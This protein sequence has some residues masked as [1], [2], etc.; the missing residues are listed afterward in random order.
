MEFRSG[1]AEDGRVQVT[2]SF[3]HYF[4]CRYILLRISQQVLCPTMSIQQYPKEDLLVEHQQ[5]P[6]KQEPF[7]FE[8]QQECALSVGHHATARLVSV[9]EE[10]EDD[11]N[12]L[13]VQSFE[14]NQTPRIFLPSL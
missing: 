6:E 5:S 10:V 2:A 12:V 4:Q 1:D 9:Q 8:N 14:R 3:L 13:A 11:Q 7:Q